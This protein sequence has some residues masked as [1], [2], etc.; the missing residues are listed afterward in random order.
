MAWDATGGVLKG[1]KEPVQPLRTS[2]PPAPSFTTS[3]SSWGA[4]VGEAG[5]ARSPA[6]AL[7]SPTGYRLLALM[8]PKRS[9][10]AQWRIARKVNN[11]HPAG[12][13]CAQ[14]KRHSW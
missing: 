11:L 10:Q 9:Y 8:T 1:A 6:A 4:E 5:L 2:V 7:M 13:C 3:I 14:H 12:S